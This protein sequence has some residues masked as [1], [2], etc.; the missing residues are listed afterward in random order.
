MVSV[1]AGESHAAI[2]AMDAR[3]A[4]TGNFSGRTAVHHAC[5]HFV[6]DLIARRED[7]FESGWRDRS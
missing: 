5:G 3:P 4:G 2:L 7:E 1:V 6:I